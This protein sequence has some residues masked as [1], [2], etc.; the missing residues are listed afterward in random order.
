MRKLHTKHQHSD[1]GRR[2]VVGPN[3]KIS[4]KTIYKKIPSNC[5]VQATFWRI[6]NIKHMQPPETEINISKYAEIWLKKIVKL[7]ELIFGGF[8]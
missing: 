1:T 6:F 4:P 2:A 5:Q 7:S 3:D 8:W